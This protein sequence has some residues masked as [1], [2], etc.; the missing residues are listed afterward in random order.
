VTEADAVEAI[1]D[2][3]RTTWPTLAPA[4]PYAFGGE[5]YAPPE[6]AASWAHVATG[7]IQRQLA[8]LGP[9]GSRRVTCTGVVVVTLFR[10]LGEGDAALLVLAG[11]ARAVL[12]LRTLLP[13]AGGAVH[14]RASSSAPGRRDAWAIR[15]VTVPFWF[16]DRA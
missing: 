1:A 9:A 8:T 11:H 14:L 13:A 12:E 2:R 5:I 7:P 3:W 10:A 6:S 4:V 15:A 16:E